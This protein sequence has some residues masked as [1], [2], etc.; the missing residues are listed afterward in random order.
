MLDTANSSDLLLMQIMSG[1]RRRYES[2]NRQ[3]EEQLI[4]DFRLNAPGKSFECEPSPRRLTWSE[5]AFRR[6]L[7][8]GGPIRN[9]LRNV[10]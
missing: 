8:L 4:D 9:V 3:Y 6:L 7:L 1:L 5:F 10:R 2:L